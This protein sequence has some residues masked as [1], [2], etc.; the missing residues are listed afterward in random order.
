MFSLKVEILHYAVKQR[1]F[2]EPVLP[3]WRN[4][5]VHHSDHGHL[6]PTENIFVP[7]S[8]SDTH[9]SQAPVG[10]DEGTN[11]GHFGCSAPLTAQFESQS[12]QHPAPTWISQWDHSER[13]AQSSGRTWHRMCWRAQE[14]RQDC[15]E[16]LWWF[17]N[18]A[19]ANRW[20]KMQRKVFL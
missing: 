2:R 18:L 7:S 15:T 14:H 8:Q 11:E 10:E 20:T 12:L 6:P 19:S 5:F 17:F 13:G 1:Q 3:G 16:S 4:T 9:L